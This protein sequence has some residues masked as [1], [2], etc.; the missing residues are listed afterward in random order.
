[1]MAAFRKL[2]EEFRENMELVLNFKIDWGK[3]LQEKMFAKEG[4]EKVG[5]FRKLEFD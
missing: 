2:E 5:S 3:V 1:M 4:C